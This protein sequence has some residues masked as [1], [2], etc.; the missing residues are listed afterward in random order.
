MTR[1][2]GGGMV[3]TATIPPALSK[4]NALPALSGLR[5]TTS[6][7]RTGL[8][9][10]PAVAGPNVGVCPAVCA[11]RSTKRVRW[12]SYRHGGGAVWSMQ[13]PSGLKPRNATHSRP[14]VASASHNQLASDGT[15]ATPRCRWLQRGGLPGRRRHAHHQA[16]PVE[17]VPA[18]RGVGM[19]HAA[20]IPPALQQSNALPAITGRVCRG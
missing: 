20:T 13:P 3:H 12:R 11:M 7:P 6:W 1:W 2:G 14:S 10:R 17:G 5:L 15:V 9:Q 4:S 18:R 16:G 8:S 19:V